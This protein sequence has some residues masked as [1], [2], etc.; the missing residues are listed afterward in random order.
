MKKVEN[1][2]VQVPETKDMNDS[3]ILNDVLSSEKNMSNNYSY[4]ID[5]MSNKTLFK[6]IM[7]IFDDTKSAARDAFELSFKKG[8]YSLEKADETKITQ[9]YDKANQ[10]VKELN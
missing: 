4:A 3:D 8:W 2:K 7:K 5:E 10:Q 6:K 1:E 9:A